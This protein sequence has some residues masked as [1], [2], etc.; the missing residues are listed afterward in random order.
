LN[1]WTLPSIHAVNTLVC[2]FLKSQESSHV[3]PVAICPNGT[4][5]LPLSHP[6]HKYA[7]TRPRRK[8][9]KAA[10]AAA[11][12]CPGSSSTRRGAGRGSCQNPTR[13]PRH[14]SPP[15]KDVAEHEAWRHPGKRRT[16]PRPRGRPLEPSG[17]GTRTAPFNSVP[18]LPV[19]GHSQQEHMRSPRNQ[20]EQW[21]FI[22][23]SEPA[24]CG[25][26]REWHAQR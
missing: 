21:G 16:R 20:G 3:A 22:D 1:R 14:G 17:A 18:R 26:Q 6:R 23:G 12:K 19:N 24:D 13:S 25:R 11:I 7:P 4:R 8:P 2:P 9:T 10:L 15:P 5:G